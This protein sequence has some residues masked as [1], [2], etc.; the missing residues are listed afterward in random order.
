MSEERHSHA[1]PLVHGVLSH[2]STPLG[3]L[4]K[5]EGGEKSWNGGEGRGGSPRK[6]Y[7]TGEG[8]PGEYEKL[9]RAQPMVYLGPSLLRSFRVSLYDLLY[10]LLPSGGLKQKRQ[11]QQRANPVDFTQKFPICS[12]FSF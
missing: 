2:Y 8:Q 3:H 7:L 9:S 11:K 12:S 6:C 1:T 10:I 4:R 5:K